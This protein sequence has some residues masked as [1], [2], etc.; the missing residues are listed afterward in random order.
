MK[1]PHTTP[2]RTLALA[3]CVLAL[4]L[5]GC[6][7]PPQ[8][9]GTEPSRDVALRIA[10]AAD[11]TGQALAHVYGDALEKLGYTISFAKPSQDPYRQVADG[12]ADIAIDTAP[13]AIGLLPAD[14]DPRGEDQRLSGDEAKALVGLVNDAELGFTALPLSEGDADAVMVLSGAEAIEYSIDSVASL[15]AACSELAFVS[16][17]ASTAGL[18]SALA[19][20]GCA[21]P[22]F[23]TVDAAKLHDELRASVGRVVVL[24]RQDAVIGD[25]GFSM[26]DG[27]SEL[28]D[29]APY[30][31]LAGDAV[32]RDAADGL[33]QVTRQMNQQA[34]IGLNRMVSGPDAM[35]PED[36][37]Q[38]WRWIIDN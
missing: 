19:G 21:D 18:D 6:T 1:F 22:V 23:R 36:A 17:A 24:E 3:A 13:A 12:A 31:A 34:L 10:P 29:A 37:A 20:A 16:A 4:P 26:V 35:A 15:A 27:S 8:D 28:F 33:N 11:P 14:L 30:L 25:E 32:D 9:A 38:R 5:A 2:A 7:N